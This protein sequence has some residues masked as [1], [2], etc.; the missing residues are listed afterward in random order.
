M[1]AKSV[2]RGGLSSQIDKTSGEAV[3]GGGWSYGIALH[4][5]NARNDNINRGAELIWQ[6]TRNRLSP[7]HKTT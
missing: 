1:T 7:N 4:N 5:R 2:E 6:K 3:T